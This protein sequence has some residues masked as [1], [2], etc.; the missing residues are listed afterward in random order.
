M[1]V[2]KVL[3]IS[4][5]HTHTQKK[6]AMKIQRVTVIQSKFCGTSH[7]MNVTTDI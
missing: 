3:H 5:L 7:F 6:S 1:R 2:V 4:T